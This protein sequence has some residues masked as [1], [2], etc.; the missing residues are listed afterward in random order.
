MDER[1]EQVKERRLQ[2]L[3]L[4]EQRTEKQV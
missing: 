3:E 2:R 4:S 1:F